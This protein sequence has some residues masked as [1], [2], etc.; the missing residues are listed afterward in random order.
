MFCLPMQTLV[1]NAPCYAPF[2]RYNLT[3]IVSNAD[4]IIHPLSRPIKKRRGIP[5]IISESFRN[6]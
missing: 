5:D 4:P 2:R 3:R 1:P 6:K